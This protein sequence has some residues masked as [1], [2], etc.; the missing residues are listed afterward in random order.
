MWL[1]ENER[2]TPGD[3]HSLLKPFPVEK[4]ERWPV[5]KSVGNVKNRLG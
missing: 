4:M 2:A 1:G 5:R 3:L